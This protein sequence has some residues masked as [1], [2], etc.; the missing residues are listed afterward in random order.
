M[1]FFK[2]NR[3]WGPHWPFV[4]CGSPAVLHAGQNHQGSYQ[5]GCRPLP[6]NP[7]LKTA[8]SGLWTHVCTLGSSSGGLKVKPGW[9]EKNEMLSRGTRA[10]RTDRGRSQLA[11]PVLL[12]QAREGRRTRRRG[13]GK[14][15]AGPRDNAGG[16]HR[17]GACPFLRQKAGSSRTCS[18]AKGLTE[19]C[20]QGP[21]GC[22][23]GL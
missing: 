3:A 4:L 16:E 17:A 5:A 10:G 11:L 18:A 15:R 8:D 7:E 14:E 12:P 22:E 19:S 2:E 6:R 9:G 1:H 20:K 23:T 21:P 13:R